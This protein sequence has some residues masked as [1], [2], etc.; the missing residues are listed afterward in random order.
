VKIR[1]TVTLSRED[2]LVIGYQHG[3]KRPASQGEAKA[4]RKGP[5]VLRTSHAADRA[6]R[7]TCDADTALHLLDRAS[8]RGH[9]GR[10]GTARKKQHENSLTL[11]CIP[12]ACKARHTGCE[13]SGIAKEVKSAL[14]SP[15]S[16]GEKRLRKGKGF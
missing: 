1:R 4:W 14:S 10:T 16:G 8:G 3:D 11:R 13:R 2:R 15:L 5:F 6:V 9:S 12:C 7:E